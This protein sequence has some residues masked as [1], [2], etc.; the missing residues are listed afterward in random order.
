M[1]SRAFINALQSYLRTDKT[2]GLKL[3]IGNDEPQKIFEC[4]KEYP[5]VHYYDPGDTAAEIL[6]IDTIPA[7]LVF[8]SQGNLLYRDGGLPRKDDKRTIEEFLADL[9]E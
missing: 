6:A 1:Q 5:G 9:E 2:Y 3:I 4:G 7:L 8:D